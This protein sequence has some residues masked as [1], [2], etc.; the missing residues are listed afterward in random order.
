MT[1]SF[2]DRVFG[3][4]CG[5][6]AA[7]LPLSAWVL[8]IL[9]IGL[10]PLTLGIPVLVYAALWWVLPQESLIADIGGGLFRLLWVVGIV[11]CT[12]ILWLGRD[13]AWLTAASGASLFIPA[14]FLLYSGV[15][16]LRQVVS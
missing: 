14:L 3:G 11:A 6:L 7:N 5:G 15:F 4:V 16:L 8:R 10:I 9:F 2:T 13:A 1:R 12:V